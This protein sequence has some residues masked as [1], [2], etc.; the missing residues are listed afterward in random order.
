[1]AVDGYSMRMNIEI[2]KELG[3]IKVRKE[4]LVDIKKISDY[5]DN[6]VVI[7]CTGARRRRWRGVGA[8]C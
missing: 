2:A 6:Q 7:I 8:Y 5:P 3:Y 4:M 1:M